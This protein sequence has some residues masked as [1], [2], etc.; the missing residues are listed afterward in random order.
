[1]INF[2]I[3]TYGCQANVADS[4]AVSNLLAEL[5]CKEVQAELG[6]DLI[7]INTCAIREKAE[8][9]VYS[10]LGRLMKLKDENP[11]LKIVVIGCIATYRKKE[12]YSRFSQVN[13]VAGARDNKSVLRDSLIDIVLSLQ[14]GKQLLA[15]IGDEKIKFIDL[16]LS[17][18]G[19]K[20]EGR[21]SKQSFINIM[22]GCNN[23]C[24]Y[25]IVPF[26]RGREISYSA[27]Q[28]LE[29]IK[30]DVLAGAKEIM[31]LGQNVNSYK[32]PE[33]NLNFAQLLELVANIEG[34]FWVRFVSPNPKDM[35]LDVIQVMSKYKD[36]ICAFIHHPLQSGSNKVLTDMNRKYTVEKYLEQIDWIKKF[37]PQATIS[38]DIIVGFPGETEDDFLLTM[39]I[40]EKVKF[41][42]VFSFI[43]SPRKY[44]K[45]A[46]LKDNCS[47]EIK[48]I[49][50]D[51]LQKRQVEISREKNESYIGK[52]LKCLVEKYAT[53]GMLL[54]RSAGNHTI[55]FNGSDSLIDSFVNVKVE[56]AGATNLIAKL[57]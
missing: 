50:L 47:Y 8:H 12:F 25:C 48:Q 54:A 9:K 44:T 35:T 7:I 1:M 21:H 3:K 19:I 28:I 4:Q 32:D 6:A 29:K 27:K 33:D 43:Y 30:L 22:T 36:K 26:T 42:N 41:D 2:Y 20:K 57:N 13:F 49:R 52:I 55:L 11:F 40:L 10:Y 39:D 46:L 15:S 45:A 51:S 14:T 56:S 24:S 31:L 5:G 38:T 53:N 37:L 34:E 17:L 18:G 16:D 23:F